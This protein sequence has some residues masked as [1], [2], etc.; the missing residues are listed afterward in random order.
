MQP[1][2]TIADTVVP[3]IANSKMVPMF[4]KKLP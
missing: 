1:P 4:W 3:M 2:K